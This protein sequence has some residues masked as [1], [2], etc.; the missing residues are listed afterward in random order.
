MFHIS[1]S[2]GSYLYFD[3]KDHLIFLLDTQIVDNNIGYTLYV[4]T[5]E[6]KSVYVK[7]I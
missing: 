1:A 6:S 5:L 2:R 7:F 3:A 4:L